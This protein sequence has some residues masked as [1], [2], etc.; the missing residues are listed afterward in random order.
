M[1]FY[2]N[3]NSETKQSERNAYLTKSYYG[4]HIWC[5]WLYWPELAV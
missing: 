4:L 3:N 2:K 5:S 1:H